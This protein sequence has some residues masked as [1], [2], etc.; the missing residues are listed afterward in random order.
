MKN[1]DNNLSAHRSGIFANINL[2]KTKV[3]YFALHIIDIPY[4]PLS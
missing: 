2:L 3:L 1:C 4:K